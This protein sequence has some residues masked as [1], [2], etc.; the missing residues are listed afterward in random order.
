VWFL[1]SLQTLGGPADKSPSCGTPAWTRNDGSRQRRFLHAL[2]YCMLLAGPEAQQL[3]LRLN[4][5]LPA[6]VTGITAAVVGVIANLAAYFAV[7]ML[8]SATRTVDAGPI[9]GRFPT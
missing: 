3:P 7:H 8:F 4:R 1:I 5:S 6:G 9:Q 2:N